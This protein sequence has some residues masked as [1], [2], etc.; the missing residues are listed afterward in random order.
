MSAI[1]D[2]I[3]TVFTP[4][5]NRA[6]TLHKCY[7]SLKRQSNKNFIWLIID[8]GST[9]NTCFLVDKWKKENQISIQYH[10]QNNQGMH[11]AHNTAYELIKTELNICIDSDDYMSDDAIEKIINCWTKIKD[12]NI[13][14]IV[15]LDA[16][17]NGRVIGDM[18]PENLKTSTYFDLYHRHG[19]KGDKKFIYRT[20]LTKKYQYPIFQGEKYVGLGY[21]YSRLDE[22]YK[23]Y[24][25][26]DVVCIVE[27]MEDGSSRNMLKQYFLNPKGFSFIRIE[28]MKNPNASLSFKFKSA[29]HYVSSS[30]ICK[31]KKFLKESPCKGLTILAIPFGFILYRYIIRST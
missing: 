2:K 26:N 18:F 9:D 3:L 14:G 5:F 21:K 19:L 17:D 11:G 29:V 30:F 25:L 10:Y 24:L 7:E 16:Y 15:A 28:D 6:Y 4:T 12:N 31:N 13:A 27:Y 23:L 1:K 22:H 8:D 20:E